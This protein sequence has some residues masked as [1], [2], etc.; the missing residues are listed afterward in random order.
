MYMTQCPLRYQISDW[1][2]LCKCK[3]NN[4]SKLKINVTEFIQNSDVRGT[5]ISVDHELL[6]T[7]FTYVVNLSGGIISPVSSS[8]DSELSTNEILA[9]LAKFGFLVTFKEYAHLSGDQLQYLMTLQNLH[10]DKIRLLNVWD[11]SSGIKEFTT[12]VV[13][14]KL[15]FLSDWLNAGYSPSKSEYLEAMNAGYAINISAISRD[16]EFRWD[17][18]YNWV[19]DINDILESNK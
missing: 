7:L 1:K 16:K 12:Y 10:F 5:R 11:A 8:I 18:L 19:A 3:S 17:W 14:F 6:G 4:S 13:A 15:D 9:Q 2:Q